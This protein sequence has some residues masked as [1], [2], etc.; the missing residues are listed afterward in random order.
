[1]GLRTSSAF[2]L[3]ELYSR[4]WKLRSNKSWKILSGCS[5][6]SGCFS[7][8][9]YVYLAKGLSK[10]TLN[11]YRSGFPS[12]SSILLLSKEIGV[13]ENRSVWNGDPPWNR[14]LIQISISSL[15][16][17]LTQASY[18]ILGHY[19]YSFYRK[20]YWE[21]EEW[22]QMWNIGA[23]GADGGWNSLSCTLGKWWSHWHSL[24]VQDL[25]SGMRSRANSHK[26][27]KGG[28]GMDRIQSFKLPL[29]KP[30]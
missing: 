15:S 29:G 8:F 17:H 1:M 12:L 26:K 10:P 9:F 22:G 18:R 3:A 27:K 25:G 21:G 28:K 30:N 6:K 16:R 19:V 23:Q 13:E 24:S 14:T 20:A 5:N 7:V 11:K 2:S 4:S